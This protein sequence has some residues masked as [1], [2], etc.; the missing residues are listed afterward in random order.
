MAF[1]LRLSDVG[2]GVTEGEIVAWHVTAG[3]ALAEDDPAVD[4][5]T[6][7]VTVTVASP[8]AGR[9]LETRGKI[10]AVVPVGAVLAIIETGALDEEG[11]PEDRTVTVPHVL[12]DM[13]IPL[14]DDEGPEEADGED[15][16]RPS[17][18]ILATPAT[19][20]LARELGVD[21]HSLEPTGA[22]GRVTQS[23]VE[24]AAAAAVT[25]P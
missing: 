13:P 19:R 10:G 5:L 22:G 23:D 4:V 2:E 11:P 7:G 17:G 3:D 25:D 20:R 1:E 16:D 15:G 21:L 9:L 12:A 8:I 24:R 14:P 18:R 6:A